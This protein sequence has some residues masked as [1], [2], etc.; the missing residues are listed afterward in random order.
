[1]TRLSDRTRGDTG[2]NLVGFSLGGVIY[3]INIFRVRE[4]IRPLATYRLPALPRSVMGVAHHRGEVVPVVDLLKR[5]GL[6]GDPEAARNHWII[7]G[8]GDRLVALS[9]E[10]I[11]DV[12]GVSQEQ[13]REVPDMGEDEQA[14]AV[15]AIYAD[16]DGLVFVIDVDRVTAVTDEIDLGQVRQMLENR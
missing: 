16:R 8:R 12:F 4:I 1:M 5:F 2:K 7:V 10:K 9:V 14:R 13:R 15:T 11:T 3:A 6:P